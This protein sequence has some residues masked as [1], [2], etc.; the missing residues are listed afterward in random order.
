MYL[1]KSLDSRSQKLSLDRWNPAD[2]ATFMASSSPL[3]VLIFA[4]FLSLFQQD[5]GS[6]KGLF[7]CA[8][9]G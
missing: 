9:A 2:L 6:L 4:L 3:T 8:L 7:G 1:L 5:L